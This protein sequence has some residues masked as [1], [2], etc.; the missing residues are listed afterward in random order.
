MPDESQELA[1]PTDLDETTVTPESFYAEMA[2]DEALFVSSHDAYVQQTEVEAARLQQA[3]RELQLYWV[4]H[5][6]R[7]KEAWAADATTSRHLQQ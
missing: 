3:G 4:G 2:A 5:I 1:C 7:L 6:E